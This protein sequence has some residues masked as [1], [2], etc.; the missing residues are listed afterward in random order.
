MTDDYLR[1]V[2]SQVDDFRQNINSA[3]GSLREEKDLADVTPACEDGHQVEAHK[4]ILAAASLFFQNLLR[5]NRHENIIQEILD[6]YF[7]I[8]LRN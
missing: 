1:K 4:I 3:F 6:T 2:L 7:L 8:L 5:T